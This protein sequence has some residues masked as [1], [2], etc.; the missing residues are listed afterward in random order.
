[1]NRPSILFRW[2]PATSI[3]LII[4]ALTVII[5]SAASFAIN[6]FVP[7]TQV[8]LGSGIYHLWIADD[9]VERIKGL[10]GVESIKPDG[11]LLMDFETDDTWGIWMKD[12]NIPLDIVWLDKNKKVVYIV[13]QAQPE[14]S[15][16]TTF[17]PKE[18]ARY[19][20]ELEA[21]AVD[22]AAIKP[23]MTATFT[24]PSEGLK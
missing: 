22:K 24:T 4:G 13:K 14:M 5:A 1:M 21:G 17:T 7:T 15:T 11:G 16:T 9:E 2:R 12:M 23:G 10:S 8:R 6:N 18:N 20:L 3:I 19:V